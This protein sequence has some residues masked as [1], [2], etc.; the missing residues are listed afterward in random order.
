MAPKTLQQL[1]DEILAEQLGEMEPAQ[2]FAQSQSSRAGWGRIGSNLAGA[3]GGFKADKSVYDNIEQR[4]QQAVTSSV[5]RAG[6]K[7]QATTDARAIQSDEIAAQTRAEEDDPNSGSSR[8]MQGLISKA[9]PNLAESVKT[10]SHR[11]LKETFPILEKLAPEKPKD[12]SYALSFS[13]NGQGFVTNHK[14]GAVTPYGAPMP[15]PETP[16]KGT[17]VPGKTTVPGAEPTAEDAKKVKGTQAAVKRMRAYVKEMR[18]IVKDNGGPV[19]MGPAA[20]RLKQLGSQMKVEGKN[21][22]ELGALSGDDNRLMQDL[23]KADPTSIG[24]N[25][26]GLFGA[27]NTLGALDGLDK[28]TADQER[29]IDSAYGYQDAAPA[30]GAAPA[31]ADEIEVIGPNGEEGTMSAAELAQ[32]PDWRRKNGHA[33]EL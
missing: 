8:Q 14:T 20:L 25:I 1:R 2:D 27:D 3:L 21:I 12:G 17:V 33:E 22:A 4:G 10:M 24:S 11:R 32:F 9:Y 19:M 6:L 26:K 16:T 30:P 18:Q 31:A 7:H 28:W 15:K 5:Q 13:P 23:I 29:A